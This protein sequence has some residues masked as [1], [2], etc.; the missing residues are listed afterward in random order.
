MEENGLVTVNLSSNR[1][2][3]VGVRPSRS[4]YCRFP[5]GRPLGKP[6][7]APYQQTVLDAAFALLDRDDGPILEEFP[8][9]I[10]GEGDDPLACQL[11]PAD[12]SALPKEVEETLGLRP[13][14]NRQLAATGRTVV[15]KIVGPDGVA[16]AVRLFLRVANDETPWSEVHKLGEPTL[17][18]QDV[19]GYYEEASMALV[20]HDP[21]AQQAAAWFFRK[22][23]AGALL[24]SVARKLRDCGADRSE[25][26]LLV[27]RAYLD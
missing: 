17:L 23:A 11:P 25:W 21:G 10:E 5:L 6:L 9:V 24:T 8:D 13:A 16:D 20:D 18:A 14:Y 22:T 2:M 26:G 7:D 3:V 27:P 1:D 4:L 15:G 19:S 12:N